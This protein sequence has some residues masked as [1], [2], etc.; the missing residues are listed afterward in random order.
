MSG[1]RAA[2][3]PY[4][5]RFE[6]EVTAIDGRR[7]WLETS[8]FYGESGGQPADR[9]TIDSVA[10]ED[11][12]LTDGEQVHVLAE[13]PTFRAGQRVLCSIDWAFRMYCMRAHTASHALYG[14]GRR[15]LD[16]LGYGGFNIGEKKVR[17]DLETTSELDDET[18]L[19]L[20]SLVNKA[21]WESRPVSWED[22]SVA[23]ARERE[24]IAFNEATEDGA[25]QKGR[26]RIVT[27]GGADENGG[28]GART[29]NRS[30]GGPTVTTSTDGAAESWDVAA[31][32]GTHVRNTREIGP[33]TVLGRSNPGEGMTRVEFSV[34]PTAI[35]RRREEKAV[36]LTARQRLGVP[37]EEVGDELARLQDERD[38]LAAEVQT[39]QRDLVAHQLKSADS[40]ER[41]GLEWLAVAVGGEGGES[42]G[43]DANDAGEIARD[44]AGDR[45]AVVVIS[46]ASGSPY[47]VASVAEDAQETI[48][49]GAVI[50]A[51]TAEFG[52]GG[53]GSDAL[54]QAGGFDGVPDEEEIQDVLES[55]EFQ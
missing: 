51:L 45:A 49:A 12:Q 24:A 4:A 33:V 55:V 36:A 48:S 25:F 47:A 39:L 20:D 50:D 42:A 43:V 32:G 14:A 37:L 1:Q 26:V 35:D 17:V 22:I 29:R 3:E 44:A 21:V 31:C 19:E 18:L 5:T 7:V 30:T 15:L 41:D 38:E 28:N 23:D 6:T 46:G 9:G 10:V 27:I 13:E 11:V 54:A 40:F 34:G 16:D 53:G 52:G 2:A 8:Y